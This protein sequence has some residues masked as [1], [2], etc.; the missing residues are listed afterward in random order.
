MKLGEKECKRHDIQR[1][2]YSLTN[3]RISSNSCSL[4]F[5]NIKKIITGTV[6]VPMTKYIGLFGSMGNTGKLKQ[7]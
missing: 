5:P 4:K 1:D 2:I 7:F 3:K 6:R